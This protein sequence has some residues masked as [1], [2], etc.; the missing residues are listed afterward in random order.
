[1]TDVAM[2]VSQSWRPINFESVVALSRYDKGQLVEVRLYP[3]DGGFDGTGRRSL[4]IPRTAPP[5][6]AQRFCSG[7]GTIARRS[8]PRSRSKAMSA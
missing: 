1:M 6:I 8:A 7:P 4:G 3:T 2:Q 5:E